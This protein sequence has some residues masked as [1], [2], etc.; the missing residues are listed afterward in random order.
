MPVSVGPMSDMKLT[1]AAGLIYSDTV[2]NNI[3][4]YSRINNYIKK[5]VIINTNYQPDE[6]VSN[7]LCKSLT[8]YLWNK[9][10]EA[11]KNY[12]GLREGAL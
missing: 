3:N 10:R 7:I 6:K 4:Y 9:E 12:R 2:Y 5:S 8:Q 11:C 1:F